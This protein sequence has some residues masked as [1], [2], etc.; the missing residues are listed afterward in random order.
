VEETRTAASSVR[1]FVN[2][3]RTAYIVTPDAEDDGR[4][5]FMPSKTNIGPKQDGLDRIEG[6]LVQEAAVEIL[7]S[8]IAWESGRVTMSADEA[9]A[10][11]DGGDE[12]R[13]AK[14]EAIDFLTVTLAQGKMLAKDVRREATAAGITPKSLRSAREE[15]GIKPEKAGFDGGWAWELPKMPSTPEDAHSPEGRA[16]SATEGTFG[17]PSPPRRPET[18]P[19][20]YRNHVAGFPLYRK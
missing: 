1:A 11:H 3:A 6:C 15:L 9:L 5:L 10:A 12:A 18:T 19:G 14:Q 16:P 20:I 17:S 2:H 8:R 13:T 7:T 4:M